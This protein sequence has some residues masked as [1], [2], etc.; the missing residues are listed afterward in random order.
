MDFSLNEGA[1]KIQKSPPPAIP[2]SCSQPTALFFK[3]SSHFSIYELA[4]SAIK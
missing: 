3:H 4:P 2:G 1:K